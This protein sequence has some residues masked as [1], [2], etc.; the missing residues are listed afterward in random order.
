ME[1]T[2]NGANKPN[3]Q[4]TMKSMQIIQSQ[5]SSEVS[6]EAST[7]QM[8]LRAFTL[9]ELLVVIAIIAILASMLLPAL[10]KAKTKATGIH[11]MNNTKQ[12][13]LGWH[14]YALDNNDAALG[15][16][17]D[18][19]VPGWCD[20]LYDQAPDGITNRILR[21]SPTWSYV[22]SEPVFRCVA[23]KSKLKYAGKLRPRVISFS[24]NAFLGPPSGFVSSTAKYKSV[25]KLNDLTGP[26]PTEVFTLLDEHENSINDAHY[27]S[28]DNYNTYN[29]NKWLDAPSGRHGGAGGFTFADGHSE[30][31][32]WRTFG[33]TKVLRGSDGSTPRPYPDLPF[34]GPS[35][36]ADFQWITNHFAPPKQ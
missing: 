20:G 19:G 3:P 17:S 1:E 16:L 13:G 31:H 8:G 30:I 25:R 24:A 4:V 9:I 28:F 29:K 10:A 18:K 11:C 21:A 7:Q 2:F 5:K 6:V 23:D 27:F 36:L 34:I 32:K 14:M 26:G 35:E 12:L 22:N 33:L 15:P